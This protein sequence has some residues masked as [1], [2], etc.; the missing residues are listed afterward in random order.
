MTI[1]KKTIEEIITTPFIT[2]FEDEIM[3]IPNDYNLGK[4]I[5][6]KLDKKKSEIKIEKI[7]IN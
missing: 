3:E 7:K 4:Y 6:Q 2:V 1:D 5:R